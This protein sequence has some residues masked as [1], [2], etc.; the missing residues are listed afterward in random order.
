MKG[1]QE[2]KEVG[3][4]PSDFEKEHHIPWKKIYRTNREMDYTRKS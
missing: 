3:I 4:I 1:L 2:A